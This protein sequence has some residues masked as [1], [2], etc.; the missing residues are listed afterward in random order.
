MWLI[1]AWKIVEINFAIRSSSMILNA[2]CVICGKVLKA[3]T[4]I[5]LF[6]LRLN[7]WLFAFLNLNIFQQFNVY[8]FWR[9]Y[10]DWFWMQ[11]FQPKQLY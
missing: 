11:I 3:Q 1:T 9:R 10:R 6:F 5:E 8:F 4:L 7:L 2:Q